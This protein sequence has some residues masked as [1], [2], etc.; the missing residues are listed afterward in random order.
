[1]LIVG[2]VVLAGLV[3][4]APASTATKPTP[5]EKKMEAQ[6]ATLMKQTAALQKQVKTLQTQVKTLT[7]VINGSLAINV[8]AAALTA[9]AL[10]LTWATVNPLQ[11]SAVLFPAESAVNDTGACQA[12]KVTRQTTGVPNLTAFKALLSIFASFG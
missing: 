4:A 8:C 12:A 5:T 10:Q 3:L 2:A 7:N 11:P 9:D 1:M 6:V